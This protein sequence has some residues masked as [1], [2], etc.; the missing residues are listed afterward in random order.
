MQIDL[1]QWIIEE[2]Y[3]LIPVQY[4]IGLLLKK[5]PGLPDWLIPWILLALG[6][7]GG[8]FLCDMQIHGL[9]QG[10]LVT[11]ITVFANQLYKQTVCKSRDNS[12][13]KPKKDGMPKR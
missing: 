9:L 4:V 7:A 12:Q 3:I 10:V 5:T 11:G 1:V 2:A 13:K 8:F 6:M